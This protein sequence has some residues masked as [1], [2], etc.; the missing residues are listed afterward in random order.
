MSSWLCGEKSCVV[1]MSS[2]L[3]GG[4]TEYRPESQA[5]SES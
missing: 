1:G 4:P 5:Q 3:C 2:L